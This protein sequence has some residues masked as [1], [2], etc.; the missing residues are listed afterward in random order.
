MKKW[1]LAGATMAMAITLAGCGSKTMVTMKGD[2]ITQ[3]EFLKSVKKSSAGQQQMQQLILQKSLE[4]AYGDKVSKESVTKVFNNYKKQYGDSFKSILAQQGLTEAT[5]KTQI[6]TQKLTEAALKDTKKVTNAD[7]KKQWK[8]YQPKVTVQ[9]ILVEKKETAQ[10]IIKKLDADNSEKNFNALAK[11]QSTDTG[12]KK[13]GG[14]LP[15]F[16]GTDTS[17]DSTFK[18]AAFKLKQGEYTKEPVKTTYG[19]HV[20]R[21]I[22]N[23]GKGKIADHKKELTEQIYTG[24]LQDQTV[25]TKVVKKVL[26][27]ANVQIKDKDMSDILQAYGVGTK[28]K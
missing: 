5:L 25:M 27:Q 13:D 19:Y 22:K 1:L 3:D 4:Q 7:L 18:T 26:K 28:S 6:R 11:A 10:D 16:D 20:I 23:P 8:S 17:L 9:H 14:K 2:K 21:M 24:W 15:A 12:T